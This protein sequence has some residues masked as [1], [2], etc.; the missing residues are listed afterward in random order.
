[1]P[2][3][4]SKYRRHVDHFDLGEAEKDDL[5]QTVYA[6][7]ENRID[8]ALGSDAVQLALK[9]GNVIDLSEDDY[10]A[11]D[12]APSFNQKKGAQND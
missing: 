10:R 5:L 4:L 12:L 2:P 7:L 8:C 11:C 3:D 6:I 9:A 1:M